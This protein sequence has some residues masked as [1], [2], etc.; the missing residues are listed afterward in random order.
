MNFFKCFKIITD[1][2]ANGISISNS[3]GK[4]VGNKKIITKGY[5]DEMKRVILFFYF[6]RIY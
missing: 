1:G 5:T 6:R 4:S 3:V 2:I